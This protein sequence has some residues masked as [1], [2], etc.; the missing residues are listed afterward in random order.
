MT[1]PIL[2]A[3]GIGSPYTRK[4]MAIAR[5]RRIPYRF[6]RSGMPGAHPPHLPKPPLP[7]LP[8][9]YLP[10]PDEGYRATSDSTP[11]C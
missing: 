8:C 7:L 11:I 6:I 10:D 5:Y 3:G 9:V 4:M 2:I 1:R